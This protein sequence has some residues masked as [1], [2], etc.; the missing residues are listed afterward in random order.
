[1]I[2]SYIMKLWSK[3]LVMDLLLWGSESA[4]QG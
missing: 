2:V 4:I 3:E 1:M